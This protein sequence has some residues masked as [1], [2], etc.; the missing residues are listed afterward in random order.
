VL[1]GGRRGRESFR[2]TWE[3]G[4]DN[5]WVLR[6]SAGPTPEPH[7]VAAFDMTAGGILMFNGLGDDTPSRR[8]W[9]WNGA[10]WSLKADAPTTEYPNAAFEAGAN[11]RLITARRLGPGRYNPVVYAWRGEWTALE[12]AGDAP[13]FS[14]QA[15]AA[16]IPGGALLYAG[17]EADQSV[18]TWMLAG[19]TWTKQP[20]ASPPR[21][22]G[23]RM[24]LD[25]SRNVVVLHGGDDGSAALDDTWEWEASRGWRRVR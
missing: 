2:D 18:G 9:L 22:K 20:G 19:A 12:A 16:S 4:A 8:T 25:V 11:A 15:P 10:A 13:V 7:G 21:R 14:P 24:Q 6:D 23:A 17:F 5:Q 1:Y 3:L